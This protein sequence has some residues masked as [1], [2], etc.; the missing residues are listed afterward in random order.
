MDPLATDDGRVVDER[1]SSGDAGNALVSP[2]ADFLLLLC[3]TLLAA[4]TL[5]VLL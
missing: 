4:G 2:T 3:V 5:T 1:V